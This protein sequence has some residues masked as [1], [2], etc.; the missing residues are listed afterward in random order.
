MN[1]LYGNAIV[2]QSGGPSP[3]INATLAG[4]IRGC[5]ADMG[6]HIKKLYGMKNGV[7]GLLR[8][9]IC[10]LTE[11]FST[12][13]RLDLEK[14]E[15]L[16]L[17]PAAALGSC[18]RKLPSPN[19][20]DE[21]AVMEKIINILKSRDIKYFF[22]IGGNDSMD[23]V[24]K[25]SAYTRS[26]GYEICFLGVPKTIDNDIVGADHTPGY[27]SAAKYIA[28]TMQEILR[29]TAVYTVPAVTIVEIMGRDAGWL[30]AASAI[31]R[32]VN[33]RAPDLVYLPEKAFDMTRFLNDVRNALKKH[34]NVVI[35]VSE[36]L[37]CEGGTYVG[38]GHQSGAVDVFGHKYLSGT[39]KTLELAVKT[40]IGCKVRSIELNIPQR[41]AAHILSAQDIEESLAIGAKSV[42]AA[43]NG[44]TYAMMTLL[45]RDNTDGEYAYYIGHEDIF[46]IANQ[47]RFVYDHFITPEGNNVTDECLEYL[48]PLIRGEKY[49]KYIDGLP[50]HIVL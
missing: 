3:A 2:G 10:N 50:E 5:H 4:I 32:I 17:T 16:S 31:G 48:L 35:A 27:G 49:P 40:E 1:T 6:V 46:K 23:A 22:Y 29:D 14:L 20:A 21:E 28:V 34:P 44:L 8:E 42:D 7:E 36:G 37:C 33:G 18:R 45:R 43:I 26:H 12:D 11:M 24:A 47:T 9:D 38:E 41:C 39:S 13:D 25:L 15:A 19:D 30:T